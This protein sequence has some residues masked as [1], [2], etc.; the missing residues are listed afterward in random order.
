VTVSSRKL[1]AVSKRKESSEFK[2][3]LMKNAKP[4]KIG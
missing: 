2:R 1:S 3:D 4:K